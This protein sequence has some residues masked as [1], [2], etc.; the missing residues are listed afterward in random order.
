[1]RRRRHQRQA[2]GLLAASKSSSSHTGQAS[3]LRSAEAKRKRELIPWL[4]LRVEHEQPLGLGLVG[5]CFVERGQHRATLDVGRLE[6][7]PSA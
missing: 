7:F 2:T 1:M 3:P 4:R 6:P 5:P